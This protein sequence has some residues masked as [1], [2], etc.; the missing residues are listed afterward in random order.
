MLFLR[1]KNMVISLKP[2]WKSRPL[3]LVWWTLITTGTPIYTPES[4][5]YSFFQLVGEKTKYALSVGIKVIAC[6]GEKLEERE[7]GKTEE[8]VYRQMQAIVGE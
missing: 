4:V 8:V 6:I 2:E 3:H 1:S 5:M 7:A